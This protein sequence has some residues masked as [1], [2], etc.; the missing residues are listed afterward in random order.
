MKLYIIIS[1]LK[2]LPSLSRRGL[3]IT[4]CGVIFTQLHSQTPA[5]VMTDTKCQINIDAF[6]YVCLST[7]KHKSLYYE[8]FSIY[9]H[10]YTFILYLIDEYL[11]INSA[12]SNI[13]LNDEI[14]VYGCIFSLCQVE[15]YKQ[16]CAIIEMKHL[17]PC[18]T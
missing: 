17:N 5:K 1:L 9:I 13:Y 7:C 14:C 16:L 6:S 12:L 18:L 3:S 8:G 11:K 15:R 10:I 4:S 2:L